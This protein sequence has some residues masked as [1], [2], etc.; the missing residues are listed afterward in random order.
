MT[1]LKPFKFAFVCLFVVLLASCSNSN[2]KLNTA[3]PYMEINPTTDYNSEYRLGF[4]N[5]END[6]IDIIARETRTE[7][8]EEVMVDYCQD[9]FIINH[10]EFV[11]EG[12]LTNFGRRK[13]YYAYVSCQ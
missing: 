3:D 7:L 12:L 5:Y 9:G 13:N 6:G 4:K 11:K 8:V 1:L 2:P 10:E